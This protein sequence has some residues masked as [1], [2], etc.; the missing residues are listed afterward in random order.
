MRRVGHQVACWAQI[1]GKDGCV[2]DVGHMRRCIVGAA[3]RWHFPRCLLDNGVGCL[4]ARLLTALSW[5]RPAQ[6]AGD[7]PRFA[8]TLQS[9]T[10]Q[11]R[12]IGPPPGPR[13]IFVKQ[14]AGEVEALLDVDRDGGAL[15]HAPHLLGNAHE[16][17]PTSG[18]QGRCRRGAT[19]HAHVGRQAQL[20]G[21]SMPLHQTGRQRQLR[22]AGA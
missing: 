22:R 7:A 4:P 11:A 14:R 17:A 3:V 1:H 20:Q 13:T 8:G 10:A 9:R 5:A 12:P 18:Q 2:G 15:Q 19:W 21:N 16:P 6:P